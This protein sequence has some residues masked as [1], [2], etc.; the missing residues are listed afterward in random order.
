MLH[1]LRTISSVSLELEAARQEGRTIVRLIDERDAE[2]ETRLHALEQ[3]RH[4]SHLRWLVGL[5]ALVVAT[6]AL[7]FLLRSE[8]TASCVPELK[9]IGTT[10]AR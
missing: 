10:A 1:S 3:R 7:T 2:L 9:L 5:P 8:S 6:S 4:R